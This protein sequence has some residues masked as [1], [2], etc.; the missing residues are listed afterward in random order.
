MIKS[1]G[2]MVMISRSQSSCEPKEKPTPHVY[3]GLFGG[4]FR[5]GSEFDPQRDYLIFCFFL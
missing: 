3:G 4:Y 1:R 5:E 2:L